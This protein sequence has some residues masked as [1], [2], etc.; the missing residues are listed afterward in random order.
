VL[1]SRDV[2]VTVRWQDA[3]LAQECRG[4]LPNRAICAGW[5]R[6][7]FALNPCDEGP[8]AAGVNLI[9]NEDSKR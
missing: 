6:M 9:G 3:H 7:A 5:Q 8:N 2:H 1:I 4:L